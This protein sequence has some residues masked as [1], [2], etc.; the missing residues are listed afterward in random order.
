MFKYENNENEYIKVY[1]REKGSNDYWIFINLFSNSI[2]SKC[3]FSMEMFYQA[4]IR[5]N[6]LYNSEL[7]V[8]EGRNQIHA[9]LHQMNPYLENEE[10][11]FLELGMQSYFSADNAS[12]IKNIE[13]KEI[14]K[15]ILEQEIM[16]LASDRSIDTDIAVLS[17]LLLP[18]IETLQDLVN[19][20]NPEV[21]NHEFTNYQQKTNSLLLPLR[22]K[23]YEK[24]W[25]RQY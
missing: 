19:C 14:D 21:Q 7:S 6:M 4:L 23:I 17:D 13:S 3:V 18:K 11:S 12:G 10:A 16:T 22:K 15:S 24:K 5:N 20:T 25:N 1:T 2:D 9:F 8:M